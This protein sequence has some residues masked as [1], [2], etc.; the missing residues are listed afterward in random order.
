MK[1][2]F[3]STRL[4]NKLIPSNGK[5]VKS[6]HVMINIKINNVVLFYGHTK[7]LNETG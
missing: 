6:C 2:H 4:E 5:I 7:I 1:Y 3:L